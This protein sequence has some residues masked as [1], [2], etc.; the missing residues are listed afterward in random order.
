MVGEEWESPGDSASR[1]GTYFMLCAGHI[2]RVIFHLPF[3]AALGGRII[4]LC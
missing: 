3:L 4:V 2:R 1:E